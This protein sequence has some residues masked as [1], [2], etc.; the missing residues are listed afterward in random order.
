MTA[1][2][3]WPQVRVVH[4]GG[5]YLVEYRWITQHRPDPKWDY[6]GDTPRCTP[7][8]IYRGGRILQFELEDE[9]VA[10]AD[11]LYRYMESQISR[12]VYRKG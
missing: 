4:T 9:A 1:Q 10:H 5:R 12:V 11:N 8:G 7:D 2:I 3:T 6:A